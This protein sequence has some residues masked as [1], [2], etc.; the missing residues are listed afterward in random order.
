MMY[1]VIELRKQGVRLA[2]DQVA[3]VTP[4]VGDLQV[5]DWL[6]G[7]VE[8]RPVKMA[9]LFSL[10]ATF[11]QPLMT[12]LFEPVLVRM[13]SRWAVLRGWQIESSDGTT[14]QYAQEWL[15]RPEG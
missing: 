2:R 13:T 3:S 6:Q 9:Q 5:S 10:R 15:V 14:R 8:K 1:T 12:P 11:Q 7:N 4:T